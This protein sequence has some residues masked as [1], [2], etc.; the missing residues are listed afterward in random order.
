MK[1]DQGKIWRLKDDVL[2]YWRNNKWNVEK[3]MNRLACKCG[4]TRCNAP[5]GKEFLKYRKNK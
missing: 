3:K 2:Y 5:F 4:C 1:S